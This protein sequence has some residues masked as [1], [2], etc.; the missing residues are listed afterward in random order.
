MTGWTGH[1]FRSGFPCSSS[2]PARGRP[3][4]RRVEWID[5]RAM[6]RAE[7]A[8][9]V[10]A[11]ASV[12]PEAAIARRDA[13]IT[14]ASGATINAGQIVVATGAYAGMDALLPFRPRLEVYARTVAF[15]ELEE[16]EAMA[17]AAC[18]R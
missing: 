11:G 16:T 13:R 5:P 9:A 14:L 3:G 18:R 12:F 15:V 4:T 1:P 6:R 17:L 8:L 7:E 10:A 2:R